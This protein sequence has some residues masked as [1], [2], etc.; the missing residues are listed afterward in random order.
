MRTVQRHATSTYFALIDCRHSELGRIVRKLQFVWCNWTFPL[1]RTCSELECSSV[2]FSSIHVMWRRRYDD[3]SWRPDSAV[4]RGW[5]RGSREASVRGDVV[6]NA[7]WTWTT[8][9]VKKT[10]RYTLTCRDISLT[11]VKDATLCKKWSPLKS[12]KVRSHN[13]RENDVEVSRT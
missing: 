11:A 13:S 1:I 9:R 2:H 10:I 12:I 4:R 7:W 8:V 6:L 5:Y 3:F